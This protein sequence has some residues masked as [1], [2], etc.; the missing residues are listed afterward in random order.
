[1]LASWLGRTYIWASL[2]MLLCTARV[3]GASLKF[4]GDEGGP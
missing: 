4:L 1:M 2:Y 3:L